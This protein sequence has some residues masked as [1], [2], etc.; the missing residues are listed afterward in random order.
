MMTSADHKEPLK[1]VSTDEF[2][3]LDS[4]DFPHEEYSDV[5]ESPSKF[6]QGPRRENKLLI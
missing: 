3:V 1:E 2:V 5:S 6:T 4:A